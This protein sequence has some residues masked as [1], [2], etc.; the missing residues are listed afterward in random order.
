MPKLLLKNLPLAGKKVLMRVDFN[1][2]MDSHQAIT[3]DTRLRL[4]LPS[5]EYILA[6]NAALILISHL[7]RPQG[8]TPS[9]SLR[10]CAKC[11]SKLLK[12]EVLFAEDC[13]GPS[14]KKQ[15]EDL[16]RGAILLLEN[17]RFHPEEEHPTKDFAFA[18]ELA[19]LAD[20]YVDDAFGASHRAHSS[21]SAITHYF[22]KKAA[23]GLLMEKELSFLQHVFEH[24]QRPFY[25][26]LGG[27]KIGSK[28]GVLQSLLSKVDALF[29][30]GGMCYT[31]AKALGLKIGNS[32]CDNALLPKAHDFLDAA[33]KKNT[34]YHLPL[35]HVAAQHLENTQKTRVFSSKEGI[36]L[37]WI[38]MDIGPA[39]IDYWSQELQ[40]ASTIF[41]N[42]PLGVFEFSHFSKGTSAI[43]STLSTLKKATTIVGGGDSL[44]AIHS[45][46]LENQ[47]THL[48]SGGGAS[49]E[50]IE[51]GHLP[52]IDALSEV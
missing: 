34:P 24:P 20:F 18:K 25:A 52:G 32:I 41:W 23:M 42:G 51:Y 37:G 35:D 6:Q 31:F 29:I 8:V 46:G 1:V 22:P 38:G 15:V 13:I 7:G 48:S 36:P 26:I 21:I 3:D 10:P 47:F 17:L 27:A 2:P 28:L 5:I 16:P 12:K 9:L 50:L 45:L 14:V 40:K 39:T 49:L 43:A 44:A 30:G 19:S 11:L 4:S 33:H